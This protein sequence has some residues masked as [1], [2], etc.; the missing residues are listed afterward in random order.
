MAGKAPDRKYEELYAT[1]LDRGEQLH[2]DNKKRIKRGIIFMIILPFVLEFIRQMTGSD[3]VFF[4]VIWV[5]IMFVA[6]AY[7][8]TVEY[9]D[10]SVEAALSEAVDRDTEFDELLP[11]H[12]LPEIQLHDRVRERVAAHRALIRHDSEDDA[13]PDVKATGKEDAE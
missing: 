8:I 10:S 12:E 1:L 3:K 4:L 2:E 13:A 6:S 7:L 5:I 11:H 9:L